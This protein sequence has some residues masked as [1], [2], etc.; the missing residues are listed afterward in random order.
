MNDYCKNVLGGEKKML[1]TMWAK[2]LDGDLVTFDTVRKMAEINHYCRDYLDS[3][4]DMIFIDESQDFDSV[5]L[6]IC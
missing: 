5:M 4:Y 3:I 2:S 6:K 1:N